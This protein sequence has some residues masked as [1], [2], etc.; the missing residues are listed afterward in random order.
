MKFG[1]ADAAARW[2]V[3]LRRGPSPL[4]DLE[5]WVDV[6]SQ[7]AVASIPDTFEGFK[8]H[9]RIANMPRFASS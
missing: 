6:E 3:A 7:G 1:E 4:A 8:V 2:L 5:L 9:V